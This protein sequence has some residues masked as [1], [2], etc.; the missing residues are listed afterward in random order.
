MVCSLSRFGDHYLLWS[1]HILPE[2]T[3]AK[4]AVALLNKLLAGEDRRLLRAKPQLRLRC[5]MFSNGPMASRCC[6]SMAS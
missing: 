4:Y 6:L 5:G 3:A 1:R 2:P